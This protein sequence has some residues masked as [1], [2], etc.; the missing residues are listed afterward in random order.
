MCLFVLSCYLAAQWPDR[1]GTDPAASDHKGASDC[2]LPSYQGA[3]WSG[4]VLGTITPV[5]HRPRPEGHEPEPRHSPYRLE[6][7]HSPAEGTVCIGHTSVKHNSA[8]YGDDGKQA[9]DI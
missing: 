8:G 3:L 2:R 7:A 1:S 5:M 6:C 4:E 9:F